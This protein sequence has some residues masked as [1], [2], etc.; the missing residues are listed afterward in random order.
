MTTENSATYRHVQR[1]PLCVL[2]YA[3]ALLQGLAAW[4]TRNESYVFAVLVVSAAFTFVLAAGFHYL[5]ICDGGSFL[6]VGFGPL[7]LFRRIIRYDDIRSV[8]IARTTLLEG[9]GIH[10]SLIRGGWVWNLWG[11][12]CVILTLRRGKICLGTDEPNRLLDFL[13]EKMEST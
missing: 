10:W 3:T 1:A 11:R 12:E 8:E 6:S 9:W 2:I 4:I 13:K 7:P 5:E